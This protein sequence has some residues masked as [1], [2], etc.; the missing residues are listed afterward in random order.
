MGREPKYS[1]LNTE[2]KQHE[3]LTTE[4]FPEGPY[5]SPVGVNNP[6]ENKSTPWQDGQQFFSAF[7]YENR[8]LHQDLP[9]QYPGAHPTHDDKN[10]EVDS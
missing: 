9:R 7:T 8:N 6:V 5:G 2:E 1:N 10:S 4:E 3:F